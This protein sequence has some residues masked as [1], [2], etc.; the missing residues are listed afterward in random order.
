[1]NIINVNDN[2]DTNT[3]IIIIIIKEQVQ[4]AAYKQFCDDTATE[5]SRAIKAGVVFEPWY[6]PNTHGQGPMVIIMCKSH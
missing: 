4:F 2:N 1:M 3:V 5:K 6:K